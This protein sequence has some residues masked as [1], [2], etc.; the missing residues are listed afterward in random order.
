MA[1]EALGYIDDKEILGVLE[2]VQAN[3]LEINYLG[4]PVSK[5]AYE[6]IN[7]IKNRYRD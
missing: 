5:A 6:A 7:N 1:A 4:Y 2:K 3:D